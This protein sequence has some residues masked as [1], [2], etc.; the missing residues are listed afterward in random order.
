MFR[1]I[2]SVMATKSDLRLS[3]MV[4]EAAERLGLTQQALAS[5]AGLHRVALNDRLQGRTRWTLSELTALARA[6]DLDLTA[7]LDSASDGDEV[8]AS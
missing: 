8:L 1:S 6:L 4:R 2:V 3:A 5:I 7:L